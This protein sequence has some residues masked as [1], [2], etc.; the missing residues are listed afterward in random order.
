MR[1]RFISL[2]L[3]GFALLAPCHA[4]AGDVI[5]PSAPCRFG[6]STFALIGSGVEV[7]G[8]LVGNAAGSQLRVQGNARMGDSTVV[9]A[10]KVTLAAGSSVVDVAANDLVAAN[11]AEIRGAIGSVPGFPIQEPFCQVAESIDCEGPLV[12]IARRDGFGP[13]PPG[14]YSNVKVGKGAILTLDAGVYEFCS[15]RLA[16][17]ARLVTARSGETT[18]EIRDSL[19]LGRGSNLAPQVDGQPAILRVAGSRVH[20]SS[21]VHF[22]AS[23]VAP[24]ARI[25]V[26]RNSEL[27]GDVCA[28]SLVV[29]RDADLRCAQ[30]VCGDGLL[31]PDTEQCDPPRDGACLGSCLADCSCPAEP[32]VWRFTDVTEAA[33][34]VTR[35]QP[36]SSD[37]PILEEVVIVAGGVAAGDYDGDGWVDLYTVGGDL[38]TSHLLRNQGDGTFVDVATEAGVSVS[39]AFD[40]GPVF[41]DYDGDGALDLVVGGVFESGVRV[42]RNL[43]DGTFADRTVASGITSSGIVELGCSFGDY[44]GDDDLDLFV[45]HWFTFADPPPPFRRPEHLWRN[46]GDGSFT[47]ATDA[48]ELEIENPAIHF[49]FTA[50]FA[51]VNSDSASDLLLAADFG[52]EQYFLGRGDGT[53]REATN[54][55]NSSENGMGQ[56]VGDYDN[57]GDLD[58]FMT[59][60]WDPD[61]VAEKNWGTSGNRLYRNLGDGSFE[62]V[63]DEAGVREGFWGWGACFADFNLDGNLDLFHVNGFSSERADTT[64][65]DS[66]P[67]RLFLAN[68]D[69][70][71]AERSLE[72][73][74]DDRGQGRAVVC[75]DYDRDGDIDIFVANGLG[76]ESALYRNDL[77]AGGSFLQVVLAGRAPNTQAAGARVSV[78]SAGVTQ[79]REIAIGSNYLSQDPA[80]AHFG[81]GTAWI[82]DELRVQ[83]T[84]GSMTV[85]SDVAINQ[86]LRIV[87]P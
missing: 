39:G 8:D 44:D 62:D 20:L 48:A 32:G 35:Y 28:R 46:E 3:A 49:S 80:L 22:D 30:P 29:R 16:R 4:R 72:L 57:D 82:V 14:S 7:G 85:A 12:S 83:W 58:W 24:A 68:G 40:T 21:N 67:S 11:R 45:T 9:V 63:T 70:S 2:F 55:V 81:L 59:S 50:T 41:A 75:F 5:V 15:L 6:V 10:D 42:L 64:D 87:Q 18:L 51:D 60:I 38:G 19:G 25:R 52:T 66:D 74:L 23:L 36:R 31:H 13:L 77:V 78:T 65:F 27:R 71:F 69:G 26:G 54:R 37:D 84:D 17:D 43:G 73:G 34:A 53:F 61:G 79:M 47:A 33:G 76:Q 56:A 1:S 86:F